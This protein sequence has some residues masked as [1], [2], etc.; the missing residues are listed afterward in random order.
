MRLIKNFYYFVLFIGV[1]SLFFFPSLLYAQSTTPWSFYNN[2]TQS[3]AMDIFYNGTGAVNP[4]LRIRS[5]GNVS[6]GGSLAVTGSLSMSGNLSTPGNLGV[7]TSSPTYPLTVSSSLTSNTGVLFQ[8]SN[9]TQG[10]SFGYSGITKVTTNGSNDL[11]IDSASTGSL[12][13]NAINTAG[14]VSLGTNS[15]FGKFNFGGFNNGDGLLVNSPSSDVIGI[16]TWLNGNAPA[17]YGEGS[18]V[19][20]LQPSGGYVGIGTSA[21][22]GKLDVNIGGDDLFIT[23]PADDVMGI[24]TRLNGVPIGSYWLG[25]YK[26]ILQPSGGY[27]GVHTLSPTADFHVQQSSDDQNAGAGMRVSSTNG[28]FAQIV[29]GGNANLHLFTYNNNAYC[30][31]Y[32]NNGFNCPS[33]RRLKEN[34]QPLSVSALDA[35]LKLKPSTFNWKKTGAHGT[36]FIAQDVQEVLPEAVAE[37]DITGDLTLNDAYFT[38]YLVKGVQELSEKA[39]NQQEKIDQQQQEIELLKKEIAELKKN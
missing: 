12:F 37:S 27:V 11:N 32:T 17:T 8:H 21:P 10:L 7:G 1:F 4:A 13:L 26:L 2:P 31:I 9:G 15:T 35:I 36:G 30:V 14:K 5:N 23:R 18:Y 39:D 38:P 22:Q 6:I 3:N 28:Y 20:D 25:Y 34:I 29:E 33:D 19:L 16:Q 24:Q